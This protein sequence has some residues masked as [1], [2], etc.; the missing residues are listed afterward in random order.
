MPQ[1]T[2]EAF[3]PAGK[4]LMWP[5]ALA[6]PCHPVLKPPAAMWGQMCLIHPGKI[7]L[8]ARDLDLQQ[9]TKAQTET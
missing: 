5:S 9:E 2:E 3:C 7:S 8:A 4:G 1:A 6:Q